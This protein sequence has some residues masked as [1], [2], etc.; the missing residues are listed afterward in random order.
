MNILGI[1]S[2]P[3]GKFELEGGMS[4]EEKQFVLGQPKKPNIGNL[5]S[6]DNE[7]LDKAELKKLKAFFETSL[8]EFFQETYKPATNVCLRITQSWANYS[9]TGQ[10]H[11][12]HSH[13][14][15][16]VSGVFYVNTNKDVDKI[17]FFKDV[18]SQFEITPTEFNVWNSEIWWTF[19]EEGVL[20]LFPSN[21]QHKVET[22]T[23]EKERVSISFN[24]FFLG[25]MGSKSALTQLTV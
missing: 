12:Q 19:S 5:T 2:T 18:I 8:N 13:R 25:Q 17:F 6:V 14:N 20:F 24:S 15:S 10:H 21:L 11:H 3:I 9:S 16:V 23:G 1:F 4:L 7:I 22:V